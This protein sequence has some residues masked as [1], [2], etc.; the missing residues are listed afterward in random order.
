MKSICME[1]IVANNDNSI[2]IIEDLEIYLQLSQ[3][4]KIKLINIILKTRL[5]VDWHKI[6]FWNGSIKNTWIR[7]I[8]VK[9]LKV[10]NAYIKNVSIKSI[11]D[12]NT[13]KPLR[14]YLYFF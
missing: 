10:K 11:F 13:I 5:G 14:I 8:F 6:Y 1:I 9:D 3:I 4:F 7:N 2:K 12:H